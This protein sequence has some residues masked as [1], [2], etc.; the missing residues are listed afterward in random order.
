MS[1]LGRWAL[2]KGDKTLNIV[3]SEGEPEL[4]G[5]DFAVE[6]IPGSEAEATSSFPPCCEADSKSTKS[7]FRTSTSTSEPK[8]AAHAS[9]PS[10][11]GFQRVS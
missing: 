8:S 1:S 5:A 11:S 3:V 6:L 9:R 2:V 7:P 4:N 10:H